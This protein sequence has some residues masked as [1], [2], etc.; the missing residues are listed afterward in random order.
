MSGDHKRHDE[1]VFGTG[2]DDRGDGDAL[3]ENEAADIGDRVESQSRTGG[4]VGEAS[5]AANGLTRAHLVLSGL[6]LMGTPDGV[7][8]A[9]SDT[10]GG[11]VGGAS[12]LANDL[13]RGPLV[14][15]GVELELM[16][17]PDGVPDAVNDAACVILAA[18]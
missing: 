10:T 1:G 2:V 16:G 15:S 4:E 12:G 8:G 17:I 13:M 14:L 5:G 18:E 3:G 11:E 9:A 6:E 7:P